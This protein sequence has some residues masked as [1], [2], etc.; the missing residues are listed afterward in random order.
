VTPGDFTQEASLISGGFY[1]PNVIVTLS[2][3]SKRY[4]EMVSDTLTTTDSSV[5]WTLVA[6]IFKKNSPFSLLCSMGWESIAKTW[7]DGTR[8]T[9][10]LGYVFAGMETRI[11]A[12]AG[13]DVSL[14]M[15]AVIFAVGLQGL[16]GRSPAA[17]S[18]LFKA[19][20]G[21]TVD[22][23]EIRDA[24][25]ALP[26]PPP[27]ATTGEQATDAPAADVEKVEEITEPGDQGPLT[28]ELA[29]ILHQLYLSLGGK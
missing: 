23:G 14:G 8:A 7:D 16:A 12:L 18:F 6:E 27:P 9:D 15:E 5:R 17:D 2:M 1:F 4:I 25:T 11:D 28:D 3:T 20:F 19:W 24:P 26:P 10:E 13:L 22:L 29:A 21:F